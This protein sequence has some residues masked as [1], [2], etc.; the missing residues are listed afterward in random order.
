MN[1]VQRAYQFN[2][3]TQATVNSLKNKG[4]AAASS[5]KLQRYYLDKCKENIKAGNQLAAR[6][7]LSFWRVERQYWAHITNQVQAEFN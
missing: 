7:F 4:A 6:G 1:I 2:R 5:L 3:Y